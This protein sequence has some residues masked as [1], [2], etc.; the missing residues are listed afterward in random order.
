MIVSCRIHASRMHSLV[1]EMTARGFSL[2]QY[3][4]GG[5]GL[6]WDVAFTRH[7]GWR[8]RGPPAQEGTPRHPSI[9]YA[10]L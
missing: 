1:K 7:G 2:V 4:W 9:R 5:Y 6:V 3:D 8:R 10:G